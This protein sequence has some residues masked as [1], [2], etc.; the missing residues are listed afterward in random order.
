M[1]YDGSQLRLHKVVQDNSAPSCPT[2]A[3]PN[4][5]ITNVVSMCSEQGICG[6]LPGNP[7][8]VPCLYIHIV[9]V[10]TMPKLFGLQGSCLYYALSI[11]LPTLVSLLFGFQ[12]YCLIYMLSIRLPTLG[13]L[14]FS[15]QGSC[16]IYMLS[17]RLPTLGSLLLGFYGSCCT[18][19]TFSRWIPSGKWLASMEHMAT[20]VSQ[21]P[22]MDLATTVRT[23]SK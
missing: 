20:R 13:S 7:G 12:D 10:L 22:N 8:Y 6:T 21:L 2:L 16:L 15:F 18:N 17:I 19:I 23:R 1:R 4:K 3:C 14:L 11:G 9:T 5:S